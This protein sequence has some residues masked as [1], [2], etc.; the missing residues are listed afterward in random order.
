MK[1][2]LPHRSSKNPAGF[3]MLLMLLII[4]VV[5]TTIW[6]N[7]F[8]LSQSDDPDMPWNEKSLLLKTGQTPEY[9]PSDDQPKL[10]LYFIFVVIA[11]VILLGYKLYAM[12]FTQTS[13]LH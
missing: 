6:L 3:I 4:V 12:T 10:R 5:C 13:I 8:A 2:T 9:F 7:P 1:T 11:A